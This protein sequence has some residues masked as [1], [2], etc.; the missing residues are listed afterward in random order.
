MI[1][2]FLMALSTANLS[3]ATLTSID[4]TTPTA[5]QEPQKPT[6]PKLVCRTQERLGTRLGGKRVCNTKERWSEIESESG[7]AV[8]DAQRNMSSMPTNGT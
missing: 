8:R 1:T 2:L 7:A 6:K 5:Q 4:A 3:A